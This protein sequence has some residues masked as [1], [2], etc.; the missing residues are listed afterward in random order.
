MNIPNILNLATEI[1]V[2]HIGSYDDTTHES[3]WLE[4]R[5]G[6]LAGIVETLSL[7][8]PVLNEAR[9]SG[10]SDLK[11]KNVVTEIEK[12]LGIELTFKE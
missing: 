11:A 8:A 10:W 6:V 7:F 9:K 1:T 2:R 4:Y 5:N 12:T 3:D